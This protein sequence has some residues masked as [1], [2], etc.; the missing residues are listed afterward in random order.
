MMKFRYSTCAL[1]ACVFALLHRQ[2]IHASKA[3]KE[4]TRKRKARNLTIRDAD[5]TGPTAATFVVPAVWI[6]VAS[7]FMQCA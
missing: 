6:F 2:P 3:I 5:A 4:R 7:A 1:N